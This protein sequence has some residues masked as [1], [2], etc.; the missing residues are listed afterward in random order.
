MA[1]P[2]AAGR[3][4]PDWATGLGPVVFSQDE[5]QRRVAEL[6]QAVSRDHAGQEIVLVGIL[7]GAVLFTVDLLRALAVPARLDFMAIS[8]FGPSPESRGVAR[9]LKDL[10]EPIAGRHV[11]L[12]EI[13]VDTGFTLSYLLRMLETRHPASLK[14]CVLL[15]R[16]RRRLI[17][18]PL[19]YVGFEAPEDFLAGYGLGYRERFRQLPY[20]ARFDPETANAR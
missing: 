13:I 20:I 12:A 7:K 8:R 18:V 3:R 4:E 5:I 10:E 11:V 14:V 15:D 16:P 6:A 19:D 9:L 2:T 17:D 1:I